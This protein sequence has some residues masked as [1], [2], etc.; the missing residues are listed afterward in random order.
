MYSNFFHSDNSLVMYCV[1]ML[2]IFFR[3]S[4]VILLLVF[5]LATL[6]TYHIKHSQDFK[7][8]NL[9]QTSLIGSIEKTTQSARPFVFLTETEECLRQEL[10]QTLGLNTSWSCRCDVVVLSYKKECRE[11]K[12][13]HISYLFDETSTWGSGRNKL[14]FHTMER[15]PGYTY[16]I[17]TDDDISLRFNDATTLEM[18]QLTPI[19]VFQNWLLDFEPAVGVVDYGSQ[20]NQLRD[21]MRK[22]CGISNI[23]SLANP[24]IFYDPLFNAFHAKAVRH[25]FP[26]DTR[27]ERVSWW[28]TDKYVASVVELKFRGQALLFFPVT[29]GNPLHR[30]YPRSL[31]GTK[32]SWQAFIAGVEMEIP[33]Q[34]ANNSFI[35]EYKRDPPQ[36]TRTSRT[37]CMNVTRRQP[38]VPFAH[39]ASDN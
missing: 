13:R 34:Y 3:F 4:A 26:L 1:N 33:T 21:R 27:H 29:V 39:F 5:V 20:G 32:K 9:R 17:F 8:S 24:T 19:R 23:T 10:I 6:L 37:Y 11:K 2:K 14:F 36:Y 7:N 31:A 15:R 35:Q 30:N 22:I 12:L 16:Y 18:R 25:I 38:I 28:I